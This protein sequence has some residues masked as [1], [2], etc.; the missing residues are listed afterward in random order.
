MSIAHFVHSMYTFSPETKHA[1]DVCCVNS[2]YSVP[3]LT[4]LPMDS[5]S[6]SLKCHCGMLRAGHLC[7]CK[8][9][10]NHI[11]NYMLIISYNDIYYDPCNLANLAV[12]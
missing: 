2:I 4:H 6:P 12:A 11:I 8:A 5:A 7:N 1:Q 10:P 9:S 3:L